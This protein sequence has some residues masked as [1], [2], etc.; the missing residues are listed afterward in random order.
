MLEHIAEDSGID[1]LD[2]KLKNMKDKV[3]IKFTEELRK[4]ADVDNRKAQIK[5]FNEVYLKLNLLK[6]ITKLIQGKPMEEERIISHAYGIS[7]QFLLSV[8]CCGI[9]I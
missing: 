3:M 9:Y 6:A 2:L 5:K 4:W 8:Q 1:P 7:F